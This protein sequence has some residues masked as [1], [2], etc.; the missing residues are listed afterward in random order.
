MRPIKTIGDAG[1]GDGGY[2]DGGYGDPPEGTGYKLVGFDSTEFLYVGATIVFGFGADSA[3]VTTVTELNEDNTIVVALA[4][5]HAVGETVAGATF[6]TQQTTDPIFVQEE[7]IGYLSRAQ[8]EFLAE[9]PY[10]YRLATQGAIYGSIFQTLPGDAIE[11]DRVAVSLLSVNI[12]SMSRSENV[13]TVTTVNPHGLRSGSTPKIRNAQDATFNCVAIVTDVPSD[14]TFTFS[15]EGADA[16]PVDAG[17][18]LVYWQRLYEATQAEMTMQNRNWRND[19]NQ[20]PTAFFEDRAS[21]YGWGLNGKPTSNFSLEL[22]IAT[23]DADALGWLDGFL[24]PDMCMHYVIYKALE[25]LFTKDGVRQSPSMSGYCKKRYERGVQV[26]NRFI[27][28][29]E[30]NLG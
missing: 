4:N 2:G 11:V 25:Y 27:D 29:M 24:V 26:T 22:L 8:N 9:V 3:E 14:T 20:F 18:S 21:V 16:A 15:Q 5:D 30:L 1:Y 17:A 13:V 6:P 23:R 28:G 12:A 10:S 19:Y 7:M